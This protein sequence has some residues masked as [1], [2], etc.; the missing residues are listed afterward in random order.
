MPLYVEKFDNG[1]HVRLVLSQR[2]D[3]PDELRLTVHAE[4]DSAP[5][6]S[7][8]L[9]ATMGNRARAR[10]LWLKN[11]AVSSLKHFGD[12]TG[13]DFTSKAFFTLSQ[14]TRNVAGDVVAVIT[15]DEADPSAVA[16]QVPGWEY[17]GAKVAQYWRK[18]ASGLS[19]SLQ[20]AVN[21]RFKYWLSQN[22]IP[23]GLAYENFELV[24]DFKDGQQSIFGVTTRL[25]PAPP[26][27]LQ[28]STPE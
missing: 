15:T 11:G 9:T 2:S 27:Q 14:L 19:D 13:P 26:R 1:A 16:G 21:A 20:C 24:E 10:Q 22:P 17:R 25:K 23:G 18:P 12:Y 6:Q 3:A 4:P 28:V 5:I 8:I 7:C